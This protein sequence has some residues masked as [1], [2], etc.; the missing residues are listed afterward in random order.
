MTA[1]VIIADSGTEMARLT[2]SVG[3]L[4][5]TEIVRH[6]SGRTS[7]A[8]LIAV[9][10]PTLV[11]ISE[12]T[13]RR[14]TLERLAEVRA[15]APQSAV[16]VVTA[17]ACSRWLAEALRAGATAVVPGELEPRALGSVLR[18]V[19]ATDSTAGELAIAA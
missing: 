3:A 14:L 15:V 8:A 10:E 5:N 6:A 16:V 11:V 4:R 2:T 17:D 7:V 13:P 19:L 9:H 18:E 12:M 1:V